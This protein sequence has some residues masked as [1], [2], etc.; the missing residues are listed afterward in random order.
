MSP[1][2]AMN[3]D[4]LKRLL[5]KNWMTHDALWVQEVASNFGMAEASPMNLR[6][7]R[8]LGRIEFKRLMQVVGES[9]PK[10]M[11]QYHRLFEMGKEVFVPDFMKFEI[12]YEEPDRQVFQILKCFAYSGMV[13]AGLISDYECG[14]FERIKGWL[15]TMGLDY[16]IH[17]SLNRCPKLNGNECLVTITFHQFKE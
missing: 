17:P 10:D 13:K 6:V 1:F 7:C 14:I 8:T 9:A 4:D 3:P 15:D 5:H 2:I 12:T 16:S 11:A